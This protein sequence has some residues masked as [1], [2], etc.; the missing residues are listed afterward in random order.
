MK[1]RVVFSSHNEKGL[2]QIEFILLKAYMFL[3]NLYK[4]NNYYNM[5]YRLHRQNDRDKRNRVYK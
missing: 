3:Y 2:F 5:I 4:P 1:D